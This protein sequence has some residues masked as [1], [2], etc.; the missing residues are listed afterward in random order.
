MGFWGSL[1]IAVIGAI[2]GAI[3]TFIIM[4]IHRVSAR[5]ANLH[6]IA[7]ER[8]A[9]LH[10]TALEEVNYFVKELNQFL[11]QYRLQR[12]IPVIVTQAMALAFP[13]TPRNCCL[14]LVIIP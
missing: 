9:N 1:I 5:E 12:L 2:V 10:N 13:E 7:L 4:R 6:D 3:L 14:S 11:A 8:E